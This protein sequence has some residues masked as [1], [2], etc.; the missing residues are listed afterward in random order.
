MPPKSTASSGLVPTLDRIVQGTDGSR[1]T[2]GNVF[3]AF[4]KR[5][6]GPF[7]LVP[8]IIAVAPTDAIP[9]MSLLTG[10]IIAVFAVQL[11]VLRERSYLPKQ[12]TS[13]AIP[14]D[15]LVSTVIVIRPYAMRIDSVLRCRL[16]VV[17]DPPFEQLV[18]AC[19]LLMA[20]LMFPFALLPFA[21]ALPGSRVAL[22]SLGLTSKDSLL[23][24]AG[25]LSVFSTL[26]VAFSWISFTL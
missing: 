10:S 15:R 21:V 24:V 12:L 25:F 9:G 14:R 1:V 5:S 22:F 19:C 16:V 23:I 6:Y 7:L 13:Y 4:G 20:A 3:D 18:G 11:M 17:T 26:A 8:S 2:F